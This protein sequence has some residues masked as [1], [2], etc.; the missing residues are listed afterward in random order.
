MAAEDLTEAV[1][2]DLESILGSEQG[3]W[4][5]DEDFRPENV[6]GRE[7]KGSKKPELSRL[8]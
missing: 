7:T 4:E 6:R 3:L 2:P 5:A 8:K 1:F